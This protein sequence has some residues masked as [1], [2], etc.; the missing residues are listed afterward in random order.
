MT[1]TRRTALRLLA[2]ATLT[3]TLARAQWSPTRPVRMV[4]P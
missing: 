1:L 4:V 2:G 3:P